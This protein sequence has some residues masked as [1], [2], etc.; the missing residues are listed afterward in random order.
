MTP[1]EIGGAI[2]AVKAVIEIAKRVG[3]AAER[4]SDASVKAELNDQIIDLQQHLME[5]QVA[6]MDLTREKACAVSSTP[7]RIWRRSKSAIPL[8]ERSAGNATKLVSG[9]TVRFARIAL[10]REKRVG[11]MLEPRNATT[12]A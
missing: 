7:D 11:S 5:L 10:M 3:A 8:M 1:M 9:L 12:P 4:I 2:Q 6:V